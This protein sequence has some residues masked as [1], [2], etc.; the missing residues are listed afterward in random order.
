MARLYGT[1][2]LLTI[3][4]VPW[5]ILA[6]NETNRKLTAKAQEKV[7]MKGSGV[8]DEDVHGLLR[9]WTTLNGIR[10]VLPLL[11]GVVAMVAVLA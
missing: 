7:G 1:A 6:M 3:G 2:A 4:I 11:G 8:R 10:S 5:T 9:K